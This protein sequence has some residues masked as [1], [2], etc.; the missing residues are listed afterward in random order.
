MGSFKRGG[1]PLVSVLFPTRGRV[2]W[3][4]EAVDSLDSLCQ[5]KSLVEYAFKVDHDD[6]ASIAA[7]RKLAERLPARILISPRGKGYFDLH[8]YINDLSGIAKGDWL[9][10]FNDDARMKTNGWDQIL[11]NVDPRSIPKWGGSEDVCL[12]GPR[13]IER[14]ISW[15]FPVLRRKTF[16]ILGHF[17]HAYSNDAYIYWVMSGLNAACVLTSIQISH[18]VNEV[19]DQV[20]KEGSEAAA[21]SSMKSL[22][23]PEVKALQEM[24]RQ[25]LREY[26][27]RHD[28]TGGRA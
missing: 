1:G 28:N 24:D 22:M 20:K 21:N 3:L 23:G 19:N 14:E 25:I 15:E 8:H 27:K 7:V 12:L 6:E 9:F 13:V 11:L 5:D 2:Q 10:I 26:L 17:S 18:F 16:E 4:N